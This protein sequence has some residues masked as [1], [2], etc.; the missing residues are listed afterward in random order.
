VTGRVYFT[1]FVDDE[2]LPA[3]YSGAEV[4]VFPSLYEGFGLPPLEAM[5]CGTPAIAAKCRLSDEIYGDA[6][7]GVDPYSVGDIAEKIRFALDGGPRTETYRRKGL[8]RAAQF[9][10]NRAADELSAVIE[11]VIN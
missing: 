3:I 7:I 4:F 5:A 9:R 11:N 2:D 6:Y 10:W 8:E 1:G